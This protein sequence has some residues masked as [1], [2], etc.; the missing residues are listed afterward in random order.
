MD[1]GRNYPGLTRQREG[2]QAAHRSLLPKPRDQH[3]ILKRRKERSGGEW[4][5]KRAY[6]HHRIGSGGAAQGG[7]G[8]RDSR[9]PMGRDLI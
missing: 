2:T 7:T 4:S 8:V 6:T 3:K 5:R 9:Q 1:K